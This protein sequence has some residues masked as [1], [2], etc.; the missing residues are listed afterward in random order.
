A[1][2]HAKTCGTDTATYTRERP[3]MSAFVLEDGAVYQTYSTFAR[4]LDGLWGMFQWLDPAPK[5]RNEA[6]GPWW[7]P[8]DQYEGGSSAVREHQQ[9][10]PLH[11]PR[12]HRIGPCAVHGA[13]SCGGLTAFIAR[14]ALRWRR[15]RAPQARRRRFYPGHPL[16]L[17]TVTRQGFL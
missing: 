17:G 13:T 2:V 4:G 16:S 8:D 9:R 15:S 7:R 10:S 1:S 12:L 5:G 6:D 14:K 11:G 3:G